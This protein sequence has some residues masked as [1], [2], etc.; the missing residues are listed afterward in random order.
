MNR[1][2]N[3]LRGPFPPHFVDCSPR[4]NECCAGTTGKVEHLA[5]RQDLV[6]HRTTQHHMEEVLNVFMSRYHACRGRVVLKSN[7]GPPYRRTRQGRVEMQKR[8]DA[9][10]THHLNPAEKLRTCCRV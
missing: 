1:D 8:F 7:A 10:L 5:P 4:Q 6:F 3:P 2:G 9:P